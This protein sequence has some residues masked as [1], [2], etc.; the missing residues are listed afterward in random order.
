MADEGFTVK[1]LFKSLGVEL[2]I[3]PFLEGRQQSPSKEVESGRMIASL[4]IHV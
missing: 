2:N 3:P 1:D 4:R